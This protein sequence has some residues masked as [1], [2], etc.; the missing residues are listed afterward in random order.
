MPDLCNEF[1]LKHGQLLCSSYVHWTDKRLITDNKDPEALIHTLYEAPFAVVSHGV[2]SD[3]IF[4]F[5]N[6]TALELFELDWE[7]FIQVPSRESVEAIS[8]SERNELMQQVSTNGYMDNYS[9]IRV[10]SS[11]A[12]FLIEA[13][14]IWNIIDANNI[15]YGQAAM[16][17]TWKMID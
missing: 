12:R 7:R 10:S 6:K 14:T 8:R 3:P 16:F 17:K 2:E 9:G 15:Y 4:N 1:Y 11:G 13:A 5:G